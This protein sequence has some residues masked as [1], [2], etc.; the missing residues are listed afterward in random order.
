MRHRRGPIALFLTLLAA[1]ALPVPATEDAAAAETATSAMFVPTLDGAV[2]R[3]DRRRPPR[4]S[5]LVVTELQALESLFQAT[6]ASSSDRPQ[7]LR[8]LA[9]DYVELENA[10]ST[11]A[12]APSGV[13]GRTP[14]SAR[15]STVDRARQ[16][17][18]RHYT[19]LFAE[20]SGRPSLTFPSAAPAEYPKLDEVA[21]HLAY[22]HERA[23]DPA[24]ARRIYLDL[25]QRWPASPFIPR[26]YLAFGELFFAEAMRDTS[27]WDLAGAAY[28][29]VLAAPPPVNAAYGYAWYR[30]AYVVA[31]RGDRGRALE[32]LQ[33]AAD[34]ATSFPEQPGAALLG[35]EAEAQ[36]KAFAGLTAGNPA[37]PP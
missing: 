7:L 35:A 27:K 10:A 2:F 9:E 32:D 20:Y 34:W 1:L 17:A 15:A 5:A 37:P 13:G 31:N 36:K 11:V 16:A 25:I 14:Q 8:R 29:K 19:R 18:I 24:N 12:A 26:A 22:E 30:L 33:R 4:P 6:P 3:D 21:Y 23:G 28:A